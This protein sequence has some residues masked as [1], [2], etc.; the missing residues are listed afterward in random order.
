MRRAVGGGELEWTEGAGELL[1]HLC[2]ARLAC[3]CGGCPGTLLG[4][5]GPAGTGGRLPQQRTARAGHVGTGE[6][7]ILPHSCHRP[8]FHHLR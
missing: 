6:L 1:L 4:M 7:T 2:L 8:Q 5:E 3:R